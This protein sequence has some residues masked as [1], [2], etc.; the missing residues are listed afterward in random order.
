MFMETY[1]ARRSSGS[2]QENWKVENVD[3]IRLRQG[4]G[5]FAELSRAVTGFTKGKV[6]CVVGSAPAG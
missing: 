4:F 1:L 3:W 6:L 2:K 5:V